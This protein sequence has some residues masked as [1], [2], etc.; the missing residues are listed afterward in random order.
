M[1]LK[2]RIDTL[3]EREESIL[4]WIDQDVYHTEIRLANCQYGKAMGTYIT[5]SKNSD[6]H[7]RLDELK[8]V[9]QQLIDSGEMKPILSN[10]D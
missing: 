2:D 1:L 8:T 5:V 4:S 7:S 3:M 6:F 9:I 10:S